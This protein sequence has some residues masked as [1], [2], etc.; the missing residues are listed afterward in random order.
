MAEKSS[1][2]GAREE[3]FADSRRRRCFVFRNWSYDL[4]SP[5][6][7][8]EPERNPQKTESAEREEIR[9]PAVILHERAS[10]QQT[11]GGA[12]ANSSIDE[13]ID[14]AAMTSGKMLDDDS[15]EARVGGGFSHAEKKAAEEER[16]E[17]AREAG[18]KSGRGPD[19]ETD[20][21]NLCRGKAIGE[22]AGKNEEGS[23]G[24]EKSGEK[25]AEL[26][27]RDGEFAL[28]RGGSNGKRAAVDVRDEEREKEKDED[29]PESEREF[30]GWKRG[31][32][33][34]GI[35]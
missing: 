31:V 8:R 7:A 23:V 17:S 27:R 3:N 10:E 24:P 1:P 5:R 29:G 11:E 15:G 34:E 12:G 16:S 4:R 32:Q 6:H 22:P 21:E 14:E 25:N 20:S 19:G 35:V 9:P 13:G 33:G 26:R 18:E 28:E 30:F 2:S